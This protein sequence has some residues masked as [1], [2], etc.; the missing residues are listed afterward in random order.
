[1]T[2]VLPGLGGLPAGFVLDGELAAWKGVE[3]YFPHICRRVLNRDM[4]VPRTFVFFDLLHREGV[5]LTSK[6]YLE[7][8]K[9]SRA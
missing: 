1:M 2:A 4:S 8:R 9:S 6:P 5:D 7:R 3:P